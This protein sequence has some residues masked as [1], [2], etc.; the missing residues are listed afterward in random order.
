MTARTRAPRRVLTRGALALRLLVAGFV[1]ASG[2]ASAHVA[3]DRNGRFRHQD[4]SRRLLVWNAVDDAGWRRATR[5]AQISWDKTMSPA[6]EFDT[7]ESLRS[8]VLHVLD[9]NY[10]ETGWIGYADDW[11]YHRGHGHPRLN[12]FYGRGRSP[13]YLEKVACHELGH[14]AGLAH[15][16]DASDCMRS[17]P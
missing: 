2:A 13:E 12:L 14:F 4:H 10:G 16:D 15:S 11:S 3:L 7:A 9:G 8:S 5:R 1:G 6:L 17:G